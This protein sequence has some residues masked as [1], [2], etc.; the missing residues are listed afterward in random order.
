MAMVLVTLKKALV[1]LIMTEFLITWIPT[2]MVT[3]FPTRMKGLAIPMMTVYW[4][5]WIPM[6]MVTVFWILMKVR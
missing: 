2:L 5:T 4:I 1:T 6:Q 3:A